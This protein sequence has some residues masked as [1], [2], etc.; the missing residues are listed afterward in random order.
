MTAHLDA[1]VEVHVGALE[2]PLDGFDC[3]SAAGLLQ[4]CSEVKLNDNRDHPTLLARLST[5]RRGLV[6]ELF[7]ESRRYDQLEQASSSKLAGA[8]A[9]EERKAGRELAEA[10]LEERLLSGEEEEEVKRSK[11]GIASGPQIG[12]S[13]GG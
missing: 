6:G 3:W 9:G 7:T 2:V 5:I 4:R 12:P 8:V 11:Q 10:L 13:R 1:A